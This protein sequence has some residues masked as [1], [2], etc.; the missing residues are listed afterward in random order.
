MSGAA[1]APSRSKPDMDTPLP[2]VKFLTL[3]KTETGRPQNFLD[4]GKRNAHLHRLVRE[5]EQVPL[6]FDGIPHPLPPFW[7]GREGVCFACC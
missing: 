5:S 7:R 6:P 2:T 3:A 4:F 1:G